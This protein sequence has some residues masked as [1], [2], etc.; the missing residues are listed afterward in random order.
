M[1]LIKRGPW[2]ID[3][4]GNRTRYRP[5]SNGKA[6][7][8]QQADKVTTIDPESR[9]ERLRKA[10]DSL[11]DA[12]DKHWTKGGLPQ[13]KVVEGIIGDSSITRS[14]VDAVNPRRRKDA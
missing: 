2:W 7:P 13:M 4:Q 10:V 9:G 11:D 6:V 3:E 1:K 14:D 5:Q 12:N 8:A